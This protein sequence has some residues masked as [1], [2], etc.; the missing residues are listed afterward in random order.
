MYTRIYVPMQRNLPIDVEE[1]R[2]K[3]NC[4]TFKYHI[5]LENDDLV[6]YCSGLRF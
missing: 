5:S 3:S 4:Q 2:Q 1:K 6:Q